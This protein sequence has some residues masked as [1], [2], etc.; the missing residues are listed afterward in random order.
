MSTIVDGR[1]GLRFQSDIGISGD[2]IIAISPDLSS[3]NTKYVINASGLIVAPGFI[4]PHVHIS[5]ISDR[6]VAEN[7]LRQ[8]ITTLANTLHS[9]DQPYPLGEFLEALEVAPNTVWTVGHT[10]IRKR[11]LGLEN[12]PPNVE[13][14]KKMVDL[15]HEGMAAGAV[16]LGTGLEYVPASYAKID[17]IIAL[18]RASAQDNA[19][20]VTHL[21]DEGARLLESIEEAVAIGYATGLQFT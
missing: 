6:P 8:G 3:A 19:I 10:W 17:E 16:G 13:E 5:N 4:D 12:R 20:Y 11:I 7:F 15:V 2:R 9:L 1:G 21:R 18:V 14:A